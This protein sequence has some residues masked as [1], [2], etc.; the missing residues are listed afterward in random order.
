MDVNKQQATNIGCRFLVLLKEEIG[1]RKYEAV[2]VYNEIET[3]P[4]VCHSQ[5][6][7]DANDLMDEAFTAFTGCKV[8]PSSQDHANLWSAA[9]DIAKL[10]MKGYL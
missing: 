10:K 8:E 9:W 2:V 6:F 7:C 3:D 4:S 5:D 1:P